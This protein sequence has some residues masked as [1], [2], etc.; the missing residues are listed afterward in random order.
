MPRFA[1]NALTAASIAALLFLTGCPSAHT[2]DQPT[3]LDRELGVEVPLWVDVD[4]SQKGRTSFGEYSVLKMPGEKVQW[5]LA[6]LGD[7]C[8][9]F[10]AIIPKETRKADLCDIRLRSVKPVVEE[11]RCRC[12]AGRYQLEEGRPTSKRCCER[13]PDKVY[14]KGAPDD[15]DAP[16]TPEDTP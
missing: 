13:Y 3:M 5:T 2:G 10:G 16:E 15:S 7:K 6:K 11:G 4:C 12:V 14:C 1:H 8:R 9:V